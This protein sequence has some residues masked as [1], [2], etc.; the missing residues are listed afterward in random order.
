MGWGID[1]LRRELEILRDVIVSAV[2]GHTRET[3]EHPEDAA[4]VLIH[5]LDRAASISRR[6]WHHVA[7]GPGPALADADRPSAGEIADFAD[8]APLPNSDAD[9]SA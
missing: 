3:G 8:A 7:H 5:L 4:G 9:L 6:S 1:A 2:R